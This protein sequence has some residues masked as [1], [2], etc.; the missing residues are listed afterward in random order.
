MDDSI[1][2]LFFDEPPSE[3][4]ESP[5]QPWEVLIVDDEP[6]VH[7]VTEMVLRKLSF[8]GRP[9]S[10]VSAF[11]GA[12]ALEKLSQHPNTALVLLDVVMETDDAGLRVARAIREDYNNALVRIVLRTG[13]PGMAPEHDV[14][15]NYDINDYKP[16]SELTS[17]SL[18]TTV[19]ASLRNY[20]DLRQTEAGYLG[21]MKILEAA[22][23]LY[24]L[25][26]TQDFIEQ[27]LTGL[28]CRL[29]LTQDAACSP[30]GIAVIPVEGKYRLV[31]TS[32]DRGQAAVGTELSGDDHD[33]V[34]SCF[35]EVRSLYWRQ[36]CALYIGSNQGATPFVMLL[37]G[38]VDLNRWEQH[39]LDVGCAH[40][41][42]AY[43]NAQLL[44]NMKQLNLSLEEK[45]T[46]RT[47]QLQQAKLDAES[48]NQA[49]SQFLANMSHEIRTPMNAILGFTE[50]LAGVVTDVQQKE[51]LKSIQTSGK[52][53]LT[54]INDILDLSKVEAGKIELEYA[55]VSPYE[56]FNEMEQ[57]FSH[58]MAEK[59]IDFKVEFDSELP[60][61]LILDEVRVRQILINLIGNAVKFTD[62]GYVKLQV[63]KL[64]PGEDLSKLDLV[65]E[66][67]DTGKGIPKD[68]QERVFGAFEQQ[69]GQNIHE[70]EGT[71]LG[72]TITK[73]LVGLMGG[74]IQVISEE[75]KG[76]TFRV[77]LKGVPVAAVSELEAQNAPAIDVNAIA[78]NPAT[79]L[80][81]DDIEVNRNLIRGYLESYGFNLIEANNGEEAV[82]MTKAQHPEIVLMDMKMPV[83]NGYDAVRLIKEDSAI[84]DI[85]VV[86]LTASAME[87][88]AKEIKA[89][90]DGYLRK[91][92][93][94]SDLIGELA[95]FLKH[96]IIDSGSP[97]RQLPQEES[98][99]AWS[100]D[101]LN[102]ETKERLPTL[103]Q[104]LESRQETCERLLSTMSINDIEAFAGEIQ[105]AGA[106]YS[107]PPLVTWG[108]R[109]GTQTALFELES[110]SKTLGAF[111]ELI[112]GI[113]ALLHG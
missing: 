58:K 66:V 90:C 60:Q 70:Y 3:N 51:Y 22:A 111:P 83:M 88:A 30:S 61:A 5:L 10:F 85:P 42:V 106:D 2:N 69:R 4:P 102:A 15:L 9:L 79:I 57:V 91:P 48:S 104:L 103:I 25:H 55:A 16:K 89:L 81:V 98:Q 107:Y 19:V 93:N 105:T 11:S 39:L 20:R 76:S 64:S 71:G 37:E 94:K 7:R 23:P 65:F 80:V 59:G 112:Q 113:K 24:D 53:L 6:D 54:L 97:D 92:V 101:A 99:E 84:R 32:G 50:I 86:A 27:S 41:S 63:R 21:L 26:G 34:Q 100:P 31:A 43:D 17:D 12:E 75:G 78:F 45:V 68:Q 73:R 14:I 109:L 28:C 13:Q 40:F 29:P 46:I 67:E 96:A 8:E 62:K 36:H 82:A 108:E 56:V 1:D 33:R 18:F 47:E 44:D 35:E 95:L 38:Y 110:M 77:T 52:S 72:L 87:Q 74:E 49:K